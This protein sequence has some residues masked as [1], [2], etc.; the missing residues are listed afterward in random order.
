MNILEKKTYKYLLP[1]Y[2]L[3]KGKDK[4]II[5]SIG[6]YVKDV[7]Y[8]DMEGIENHIILETMPD[9]RVHKLFEKCHACDKIIFTGHALSP[10]SFLVYIQ[11]PNEFKD[12][13]QAFKEG[14]YSDMYTEEQV[15]KIFDKDK[16]KGI[17]DVL[18]KHMP[19]FDRYKK[20]I[21]KE[22][23]VVLD[24]NEYDGEYEEPVSNEEIFIP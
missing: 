15:E 19:A 1:L 23:G 18:L 22:W 17:V 8:T 16:K 6:D 2:K 20:H 11:I 10:K 3:Y 14:R 12:T 4:G 13:W 9:K 24:Y 7:F 21:D 5:A